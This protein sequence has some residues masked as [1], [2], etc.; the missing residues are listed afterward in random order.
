M[1]FKLGKNPLIFSLI[2]EKVTINTLD[3]IK[4]NTNGVL[5]NPYTEIRMDRVNFYIN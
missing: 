2:K 4:E 1:L 5:K 3:K